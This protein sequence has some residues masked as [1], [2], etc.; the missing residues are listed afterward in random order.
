MIRTPALAATSLV[1]VV[2]GACAP[3]AAGSAVRPNDPTAAQAVGESCPIVVDYGQPLVVDCKPH[4]RAN[5]E[6]A[7]NAGVAVVAYDCHS[8][9][10]LSDCLDGS[11]GTLGVSRKEEVIELENADEIKANLPTFGGKL[12]IDFK[13]EMQRGSALNLA[14][15]MVGKKRTTVSSA[16]RGQ[17]RGTCDGATHF[18]RGAFMREAVRL[19]RKACNAGEGYSCLQLNRLGEML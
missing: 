19:Y 12:A 9:R 3:G 1:A 6:E 15:I 8:L 4:Q 14:M 17:L 16:E 5:L 13:A 18:V 11:Y 10:L 7:M 2:L